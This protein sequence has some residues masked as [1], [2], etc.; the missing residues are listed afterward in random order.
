M[1]IYRRLY[2]YSEDI[3]K[4]IAKFLSCDEK[5][6]N[7]APALKAIVKVYLIL[8]GVKQ[9][10]EGNTAVCPFCGYLYS[11]KGLWR[12]IYCA[13]YDEL[14]KIVDEYMKTK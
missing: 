8:K 4:Q 11:R 9:S 12:H 14:L 13:H 5:S 6:L 2:K 10:C 7:S 3:P 1:G